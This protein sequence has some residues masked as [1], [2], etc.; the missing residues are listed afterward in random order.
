M[1]SRG[2]GQQP[3]R[4]ALERATLSVPVDTGFDPPALLRNAHLQSILPSLPPRRWSA[5]RRSRRLRATARSWLLDCGAL[6]RLQAWHSPPMEPNGR[7]ALLLHGWEGSADSPYVQS[8]GAEL[9][10]R[11]Y[12]VVRLNLRDHGGTQDLNQELFHSCRLPEVAA[13]VRLV[14]ERA[15]GARLY[16]AGFSLG[17]NFLLRVACAESP[18]D[19]LA[20]VV[21]ISPVIDPQHTLR[22]LEQGWPLYHAYFVRRWSRSLRVKQR[23]W[24]QHFE[25]AELVKSGDLRAMTAALVEQHTDFPSCDAYLEGYSITGARL[26][27]LHCPA[28]ILI[29]RDDPIIPSAD[30]PRLAAHPLLRIENPAHGGHCGFMER[31]AGPGYADRFVIAQFDGFGQP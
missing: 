27:T 29:A 5:W 22:A 24:P 23:H 16:L 4:S 26:R 12:Q 15:A 10:A 17:G 9:L 6:G 14:A 19:N 20:G 13:A 30:L 21:A 1:E 18:P 28:R 7:W 3:A 25:F 31:F 2:G 11:G 8:L